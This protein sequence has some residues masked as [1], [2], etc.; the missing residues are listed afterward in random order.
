MPSAAI[1][2]SQPKTAEATAILTPE[3]SAP[4]FWTEF[5]IIFWQTAPFT[6]FWGYVIDQQLSAAFS[7]AG[8]PHWATVLPVAALVSCANAFYHAN[9]ATEK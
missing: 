5:D 3:A 7:V 8:A 2:W 6:I 4:G 1:N 9:R